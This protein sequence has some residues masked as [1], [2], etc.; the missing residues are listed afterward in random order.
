MN[1]RAEVWVLFAAGALSAEKTSPL[2]AAKLADSLLIE[3]DSRW[4]LKKDGL[5]TWWE[6]KP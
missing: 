6:K 3:F 2:L 5:A 1:S 4:L